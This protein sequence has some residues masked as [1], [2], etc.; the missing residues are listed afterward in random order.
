MDKEYVID[1]HPISFKR[2][3]VRICYRFEKDGRWEM[4]V[5]IINSPYVERL[6]SNVL[7][8]LGFVK[9]EEFSLLPLSSLID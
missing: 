7:E 6:I 9:V 3:E 1:R 2:K 5:V 4:K 8:S